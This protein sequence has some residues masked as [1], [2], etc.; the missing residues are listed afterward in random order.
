[1]RAGVLVVVMV[2]G[3]VAASPAAASTSGGSSVSPAAR[4]LSQAPLVSGTADVGPVPGLMATR[5]HWTRWSE[6]VVHG[7]N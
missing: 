1:M 6:R 2:L 3:L 4:V 7:D 5:V